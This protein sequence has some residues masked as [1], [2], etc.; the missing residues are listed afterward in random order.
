[1]SDKKSPYMNVIQVHELAR[2]EHAAVFDCRAKLGVPGWGRNAFNEGHI[3]GAQFLDLDIDLAAPPDQRGRHPLPDLEIWLETVR[4]LGVRNSDQIVI[5]DDASG[6]YA[7]RAW[8]MFRWIGHQAVAVLDGGL[9]QW[10]SPLETESAARP[11][12]E[13]EA[14]ASLTQ[15]IDSDQVARSLADLNLVDARTQARFDGE[16]EPIDPVA[17]H[18]P[19]AVCLPFQGNL[20]ADGRFLDADELKAR[21]TDQGD[22][23]VCY[24]GSGVTACHNI[25]AMHIAGLPEPRLYADSW[26]GWITDANRPIA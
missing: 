25:L 2:L 12:S 17:G 14:R 8:W 26:S 10:Q 16:E 1:M 20:T 6:A 4:R 9:D 11:R 3:P 22:N 5:Y 7:A 15:L 19:G 13:F 24:C 23:L 21:F 18:I